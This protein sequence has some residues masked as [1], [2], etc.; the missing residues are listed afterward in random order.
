MAMTWVMP[1]GQLA[2]LRALDDKLARKVFDTPTSYVVGNSP[3]PGYA[4]TVMPVFYTWQPYAAA[5]ST[6]TGQAFPWVCYDIENW[7][8]TDP[9]VKRCPES[10]LYHFAV[11]AHARGQKVVAAPSRDIIYASGSHRPAQPPED[12]NF[13]YLRCQ[14]PA[15]AEDADALVCQC[16]GA[17]KDLETYGRMLVGAAKQAPDGQL[18]WGGLTTNFATAVQMKAAYDAAALSGAPVTGYWVTIASQAQAPVAADFFR[19]V[20]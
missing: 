2:W 15:A 14:V 3:V 10:A 19:S 11:L 8:A 20:T 9:K 13:G 16:Q 6:Q 5:G 7:Q 12:I 4:C 1:W 18:L 17:E